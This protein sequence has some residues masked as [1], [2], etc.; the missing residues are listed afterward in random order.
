LDKKDFF[1]KSDPFLVIYRVDPTGNREELVQTEVI[2]NNLSPEWKPFS[3]PVKMLG[4]NKSEVM[5]EVECRDSDGK[6]SKLIG[7]F[8]V[9]SFFFSFERE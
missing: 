4:T 2:D 5:I 6:T 3:I 8:K 7:S 1:G 9:T